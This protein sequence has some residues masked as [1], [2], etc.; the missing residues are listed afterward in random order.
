MLGNEY[1]NGGYVKDGDPKK[2]L[3]ECEES[4]R[5][6]RTDYIDLYLVHRPDP[7]TPFEETMEALNRL[8]KEGK[9]PACGRV[10]L[11]P[12]ADGGSRTD[13]PH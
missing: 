6:L 11:Q 5:N 2:I 4:L 9:Y 13:L 3:R 10:Q 1:I 12:R 8:K 7:N